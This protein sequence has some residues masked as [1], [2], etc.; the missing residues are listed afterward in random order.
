MLRLVVLVARVDLGERELVGFAVG[1]KDIEQGLAAVLG[2][3]GEDVLRPDLVG[4]EALGEL[5]QLPQVG[6]RL[7]RRVDE[8][9]PEVG[10]PLGVA[11][12]AFLLDP[13]RGRQDE[14]GRHR[15]DGRIGVGDHD[16]VRGVAVAR[17]GLVVGVRRRLEV[18]VAHD[19]VGVELAV[20]EHAVLLHGV[21]A[22]LAGQEA[23]REL[24]D[25]LGVLAVLGIGDLHVGRKA[26]RE[27]ADLARRAAGGRL[28]G[29]RERAVAGLR[30]LPGQEVEVVDH[31]VRPHAADVLVEPHGPE[32]HHLGLRVGVELGERSPASSS[33]RPRARTPC[34]P[35]IRP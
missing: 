16:E 1:E 21:V 10:P 14:V 22:D 2:R 31:V 12:G 23:L 25:V 9:V 32:R 5:H 3:L 17:I 20:L 30:D 8:L 28:P 4:G 13:H 34:R 24:P 26:M 19:P 35:C 33:A 7:A 27:G 18:V 15:G 11:V 29:E 6:A